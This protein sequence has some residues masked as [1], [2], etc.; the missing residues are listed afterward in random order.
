[1]KVLLTGGGGYIGSHTLLSLAETT[2]HELFVFDNFKNGHKKAIEQVSKST[3]KNIEVY[4]GELLD[5]EKITNVL[6]EVQPDAVIHFAALIEA[7]V[8]V[9]HP[10]KFFENNVVGSLNLFKAM[11]E[12]NVRNIIFSST[13]AV[14][15]TPE[16]PEVFE[17]TEL[18]PESAYGSSKLMVEN[19]LRDLIQEEVD[20]S[21]KINHII[22]RY[23]N[24][25]GSDPE[26]RIGQDY[27]KPTHLMTVAIE[28]ALGLRD[29]FQIFGK[30]YPTKDG[31]CIRDYIHVA[32]L[33]NAHVK[34]L[35][36]L[37]N[38][39]SS[40]VFNIGTGTGYT[41][42]EVVEELKKIHG[43]FEVKFGERRPGDPVAFYA[44]NSKAKETL[45]WEPKFG[46]KD[47]LEH[48]YNW[49]KNYP[50][51]FESME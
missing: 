7:G 14:Y 43:D 42:L 31:T 41:N 48:A 10:T 22:L 37:M 29:N 45:N 46:L 39:N 1:M 6:A 3:N 16:N 50:K 8:S 24:A 20:E 33:A 30:D 44:N 49:K 51:G 17:T 47:M 15:G 26:M 18:K 11:Q 35:E 34:A 12:N 5:Q 32:D 28:Y 40:D 27:P 21:E 13:A 23:F 25:A 36:Y 19:I 2:E 4:E 9:V 38:G